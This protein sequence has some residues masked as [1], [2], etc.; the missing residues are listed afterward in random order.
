MVPQAAH[1]REG[2]AAVV[3]AEQRGGLHSGVEDLG[4]VRGPGVNCQTRAN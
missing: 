1:Q 4:L 2:T 3:A